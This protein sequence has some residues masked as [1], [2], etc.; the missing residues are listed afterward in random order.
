MSLVHLLFAIA[1]ILLGL[2]NTTDL[3]NGA[4]WF[5]VAAAV[6]AIVV[7]ATKNDRELG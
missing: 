6:L 2:V 1:L 4:S 3:D 5:A 7:S